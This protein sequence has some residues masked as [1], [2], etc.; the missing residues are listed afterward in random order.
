MPLEEVRA[1][2]PTGSVEGHQQSSQLLSAIRIRR[3][4]IAAVAALEHSILD[5]INVA[6]AVK[7]QI[8]ASAGVRE[9]RPGGAVFKNAAIVRIDIAVA[10]KVETD[11]NGAQW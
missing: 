1:Y 9:L 3:N 6:I 7:V 4:T 11:E 8:P 2:S 5:L 10:I